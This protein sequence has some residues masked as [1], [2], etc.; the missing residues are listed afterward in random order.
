MAA[1]PTL[2]V[3]RGWDDLA[4]AANFYPPDLPVVWRLTYFANEHGAVLLPWHAWRDQTP[5]GLAA[6]QADVQPGFRFFLACP[7]AHDVGPVG[8]GPNDGPHAV[9]RA[10][11]AA[12]ATLGPS[13]GGWIIADPDENFDAGLTDGNAADAVGLRTFPCVPAA[14][15]TPAPTPASA[16]AVIAPAAAHHPP[17][18]ARN[19]LQ[20]LPRPPRLVILPNPRSGDLTAWGHL[21][22]LLGWR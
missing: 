19:W 3:N 17:R 7:G 20:S 14:T 22:T 9:G 2:I 12:L 10:R 13:L 16:V 11:A 4:D 8:A 6:W 21:L 15:S 18:A 5:S 1:E